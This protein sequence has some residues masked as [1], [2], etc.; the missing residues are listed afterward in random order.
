MRRLLNED[1]N[2]SPVAGMMKNVEAPPD[3]VD[4]IIDSLIIR[5]ENE[6][7]KD[8]EDE[9]EQM[10]ESLR[11]KSLRFLFEQEGDAAGA[12]PNAEPPEGSET[13]K[14]DVPAAETAKP[15][16]DIDLFT[17]K[18]ARLVLNG[19]NMIPLEEVIIS[20]A[21]SFLSKNY[22]KDYVDQ[23]QDILDQQFDFDLTGEEDVIDVPIAAGAAGK[24][25]GA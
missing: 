8:E 25:S 24:S 15:P 22:G 18:I 3:S 5:Y 7:V 1:E 11:R 14:E 21:Q 23:M 13:P 19:R 16:L 10:F 6:S 20:R 2:D 4:D 12:E 9:S 17:K